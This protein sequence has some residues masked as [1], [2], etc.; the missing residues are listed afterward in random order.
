MLAAYPRSAS[1]LSRS[2]PMSHTRAER[3]SDLG[4]GNAPPGCESSS[5][6][7]SKTGDISSSS[8][9]TQSSRTS[10]PN[11]TRL[12]A[13]REA[14]GVPRGKFD[15]DNFPLDDDQKLRYMDGA[16][17]QHQ[18]CQ[19]W[20]IWNRDNRLR[21]DSRLPEDTRDRLEYSEL[22][23]A[24]KELKIRSAA[25]FVHYQKEQICTCC[26]T[27][28]NR[29]CYCCKYGCIFVRNSRIENPEPPYVRVPS[30]PKAPALR[31]VN[32]EV[33]PVALITKTHIHKVKPTKKDKRTERSRTARHAIDYDDAEDDR[34]DVE[35]MREQRR[36]EA[37]RT[38]RRERV[39]P[40]LLMKRYRAPPRTNVHPI[41][42]RGD[43]WR[44]FPFMNRTNPKRYAAQSFKRIGARFFV[45]TP[46][47]YTPSIEQ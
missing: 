19:A 27:R 35:E 45:A 20:M 5:P 40:W 22:Q 12:L 4:S 17:E 43:W 6:F 23:P 10:H 41:V 21:V 7:Q 14:A 32:V 39:P 26:R 42:F 34:I 28:C 30:P 46:M 37:Y 11:S 3:N 2:V 47:W 25:P 33:T 29:T 9:A 36:Y 24:D 15:H 13:S 38:N 16:N 1:T 8:F 44:P 18:V 31:R